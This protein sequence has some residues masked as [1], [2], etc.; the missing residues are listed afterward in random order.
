MKG[1]ELMGYCYVSPVGYKSK[2]DFEFWLQ[3][4]LDFNPKAKSSKK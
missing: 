2:K 3:L 4:C 1:K